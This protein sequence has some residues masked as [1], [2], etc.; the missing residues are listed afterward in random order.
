M[1]LSPDFEGLARC[2]A[3]CEIAPAPIDA[4]I[5]WSTILRPARP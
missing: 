5:Y 3:A 4:G 1:P 2:S